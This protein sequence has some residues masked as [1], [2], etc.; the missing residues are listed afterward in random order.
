M[1]KST[2][3][4]EPNHSEYIK[5]IFIKKNTKIIKRKREI[6]WGWRMEE[7][8]SGEDLSAAWG[9]C[10]EHQENNTGSHLPSFLGNMNKEGSETV[11]SLVFL[12]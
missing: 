5:H 8:I 7:G 4:G 9:D 3:L 10:K 11:C 12:F 6:C 1:Q 2:D